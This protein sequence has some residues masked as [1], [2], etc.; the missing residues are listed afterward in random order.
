MMVSLIL[1]M[2]EHRGIGLGN[3]L[4]WRLPDD[5]KRFKS[6]TMGHHVIL[7]R[8]TW[9][10]IRR[11]LPG[12]VMI[13]VSR[14]AAFHAEGVEK[15][16]SLDE[17]LENARR[18]GESEAFVIGGGQIFAQALPQA[19]RIYLTRVHASLPADTFFPALDLHEW[20]VTARE[21][22]GADERHE[23]AFTFETLERLKAPGV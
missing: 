9:E 5:L 14:S 6:L 7:G 15:A 10:T 13:V 23:H 1:A 8:K 20:R 11:P 19:D 3:G 12:R 22:H 17:A 2:D 18:A 4:P 16:S 21:Y